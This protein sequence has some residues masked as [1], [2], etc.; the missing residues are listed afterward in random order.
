LRRFHHNLPNDV[1]ISYPH[2]EN[3]IDGWVEDFHRLLSKELISRTGRQ[4][5]IWRDPKMGPGVSFDDV[6]LNGGGKQ[7]VTGGPRH[8]HTQ[9][10]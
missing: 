7:P 6:M 9:A 2:V 10:A 3:S 4:I 5:E 1:F 8:P